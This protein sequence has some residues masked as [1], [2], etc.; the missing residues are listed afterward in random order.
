MSFGGSA[1][2][3]GSEGLALNCS[4][5]LFLFAI[6]SNMVSGKILSSIILALVPS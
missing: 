5:R 1:V 4:I 2:R 6:N 3:T